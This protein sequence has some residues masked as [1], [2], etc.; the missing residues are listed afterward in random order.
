MMTSHWE[1]IR[2]IL[3]FTKQPFNYIYDLDTLIDAE[4]ESV[5]SECKRGFIAVSHYSIPKSE[6]FDGELDAA[7]C[8]VLNNDGLVW[9]SRTQ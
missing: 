8:F 5:K 4:S 1:V 2:F 3:S 6:F 7:D 9:R